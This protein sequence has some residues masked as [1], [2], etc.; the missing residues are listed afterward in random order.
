MV[1]T[2]Y[3]FN[4][5]R[6]RVVV[7]MCCGVSVGILQCWCVELSMCCSIGVLRCWCAVVLVCCGVNTIDSKVLWC[8]SACVH[9]LVS[10]LPC[11]LEYGVFGCSVVECHIVKVA[12]LSAI[13]D[14]CVVESAMFCCCC[15]QCCA[16]L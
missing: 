11:R 8:Q 6:C 16:K 1:S 9:V 4:V 10:R 15:L 3:G 7:S 2:R 13:L 5:L 14:C 12:V